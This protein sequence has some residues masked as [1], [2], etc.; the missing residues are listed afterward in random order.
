[1]MRCVSGFGAR[2]AA[3]LLSLTLPGCASFGTVRSAEVRPGTSI[4]L[5]G[6]VTS[7]PGDDAGWFWSYD[8]ASRCNHPIPAADIGITF[9]GA[10][11]EETRRP[12]EFGVGVSGIVYPYL[13]SYVQ[14]GQGERP[15]GLGARVG[16]PVSGWS[17]HQIYGRYDFKRNDGRRF[18]LNPAL[19]LH[20][21]NSP[22]GEN[23]GHVLAF[24]QGIGFPFEGERVSFTPA[25]SFVVGRSER[26][27]GHLPKESSMTLFGVLSLGLTIHGKRN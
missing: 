5:Q 15:Y 14:L 26:R 23:P 24:V 2:W 18:L 13:D 20:T 19:F 27:M 17:Q 25:L 11:P 16:I 7:P 4:T 1:M 22:N 12:F 9:A 3:L 10:T 6:T 21:G 8:C